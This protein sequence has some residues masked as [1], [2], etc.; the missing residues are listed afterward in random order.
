MQQY[1]RESGINPA[2]PACYFSYFL[3]LISLESTYVFVPAGYCELNVA[4]ILSLCRSATSM[5][6]S[7][8]K[9]LSKSVSV[10]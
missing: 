4:C 9:P 8:Q 10:K 7:F 2:I 3:I 6:V 5:S 1:N